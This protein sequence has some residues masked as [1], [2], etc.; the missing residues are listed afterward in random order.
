MIYGEENQLLF[1][2]LLE[3]YETIERET[4]YI[5]YLNKSFHDYFLEEG[6]DDFLFNPD[7]F[8]TIKPIETIPYTTRTRA[9]YDKCE[10]RWLYQIRFNFN[11]IKWS[12][13]DNIRDK[14]GYS[15]NPKRRSIRLLD[16]IKQIGASFHNTE[17]IAIIIYPIGFQTMPEA[18]KIEEKAFELL[19]EY[20]VERTPWI[21]EDL[22]GSGLKRTAFDGS[23]ELF[24]P[25]DITF[26]ILQEVSL[27]KVL[28]IEFEKTPNSWIV[29]K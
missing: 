29:I 2:E 3:V 22:W 28:N 20:G 18:K 12:D 1:E 11:N 4:N 26:D 21:C 8:I 15:N 5:K 24:M 16:E 7:S 6:L 23:T 19:E 17:I 9:L 14:I 25:K 10:F 27:D 13:E